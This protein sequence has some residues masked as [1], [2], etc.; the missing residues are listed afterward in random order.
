M[1]RD[2]ADSARSAELIDCDFDE[3]ADRVESFLTQCAEAG[4]QP[5]IVEGT[6]AFLLEAMRVRDRHSVSEVLLELVEE[7]ISRIPASGR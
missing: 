7:N 2:D 5:I 1:P 4:A 6:T 3:Y